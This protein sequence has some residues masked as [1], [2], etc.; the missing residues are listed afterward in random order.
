VDLKNETKKKRAKAT[1][2]TPGTQAS[3]Q[4]G[5]LSKQGATS[6]SKLAQGDDSN[7]KPGAADKS[8]GVQNCQ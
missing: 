5:E 7:S 6:T 3:Y 2:G 1:K 4:K 8:T